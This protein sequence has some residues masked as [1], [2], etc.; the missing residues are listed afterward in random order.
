MYLGMRRKPVMADQPGHEPRQSAQ[1]KAGDRSDDGD[2]ELDRRLGFAAQVGDSAEEKQDDRPSVQA[3]RT[4]HQR[5]RDLVDE[6]RSED[7]E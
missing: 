5:V 7:E 2:G 3:Q 4:S 6:D 1:Q